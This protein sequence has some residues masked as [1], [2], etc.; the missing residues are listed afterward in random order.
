M[1]H[2][3][4]PLKHSRRAPQNPF[5][6]VGRIALAIIVVLAVSSTSVAAIAVWQTV[7]RIKPGIQLAQLPGSTGVAVPSVG[8]IEGE[9]NLLL[10]G[11]DTRTNQ[12]GAFSDSANQDA[13]SGLG[14]N[15]V[16]MLLHVSADHTNAT[17]VS[18]PRDLMVP[19]PECPDPSGDGSTVDATDLAMFNTTLSRGGLSCTVL[20]VEKMTGLTIPYA[21]EISFDGV[22]AMSN[23]VGGVT[24]CL[25][26]DVTDSFTGLDLKAGNQTL[27]G[28]Q[29]LAFVRSR[30]GVGDGSDLGRISNQQVFLSS[31]MRKITSAGVLTNPLT[32]YSLA[33]AAVTNMQLSTTLTDP[34]AMVA[35][36]LALK[37]ISLSSMVFVQYPSVTDPDD[38]NRVI[39]NKSAALLLN[40]ALQNNQ[41]ISLTG[42]T[43]VAAEADP[44]STSTPTPTSTADATGTPTDSTTGTAAPTDTPTPTPSS[45]VVSLPTSVSGQTA[46]EQTCTVGNN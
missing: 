36:A 45:T 43:G 7:G 22:I 38:V 11:T 17:V 40:T 6:T 27:V 37:N 21:A 42:G 8:A 26:T 13:S 25:A 9:V 20:T 24:V 4:Q 5:A 10:V 34:T 23:A 44:S 1:T 18:F 14:N 19:V 35:I 31:L 33:N 41:P 46:A 15:D 28:D 2:H 29:A 30:H 3:D 32:L 39:P 12:G 16:T